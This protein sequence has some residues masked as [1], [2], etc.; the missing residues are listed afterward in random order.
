MSLPLG[1]V[2]VLFIMPV[3]LPGSAV[4]LVSAGAVRKKNAA[5]ERELPANR[6]I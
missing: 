3:L 1:I 5:V 2:V 4:F 6:M